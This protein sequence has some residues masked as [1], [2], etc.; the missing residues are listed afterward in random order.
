MCH[1]AV[2]LCV[3]KYVCKNCT[4][5]FL[6]FLWSL[7]IV[8]KR[9]LS[10]VDR[11]LSILSRFRARFVARMCSSIVFTISTDQR[12][13]VDLAECFFFTTHNMITVRSWKTW[14]SVY[15]GWP[16]HLKCQ[17]ISPT[18]KLRCCGAQLSCFRATAQLLQWAQLSR[19]FGWFWAVLVLI[20]FHF[21]R[22]CGRLASRWSL[23]SSPLTAPN[24][25]VSRHCVTGHQ[26]LC[27]CAPLW[28]L[29]SC[30]GALEIVFVLLLS[31]AER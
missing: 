7:P 14:L 10:A 3:C 4:G 31:Q 22:I 21:G 17:G 5:F 8:F 16:F 26:P 2:H 27:W 12:W 28:W 18:R 23:T 25:Y 15:S 6:A 19:N 24:W 30:Y 1:S 11:S 13:I 29:L 20:S 9:D